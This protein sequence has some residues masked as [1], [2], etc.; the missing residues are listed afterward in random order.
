VEAGDAAKE[1]KTAES[2]ALGRAP[3]SIERAILPAARAE[4]LSRGGYVRGI[5]HGLWLVVG[6]VE[7]AAH[8]CSFPDS[9]MQGS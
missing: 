8:R 3:R 2:A 6:L 7:K 9:R 1:Q 5:F 4:G